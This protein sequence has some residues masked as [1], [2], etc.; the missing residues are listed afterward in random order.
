MGK[1]SG[2][3]RPLNMLEN[4]VKATKGSVAHRKTKAGRVRPDGTVYLLFNLAGEINKRAAPEVLNADALVC[5]DAMKYNREFSRTPTDYEKYYNIIQTSA[6]EAVEECMDVPIDAT[7]AI[8]EAF[9]GLFIV[10][11]TRWGPSPPVTPN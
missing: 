10:I 4:S 11:E 8:A 2:G 7:V 5:E 3:V 9:S 1:A 6:C